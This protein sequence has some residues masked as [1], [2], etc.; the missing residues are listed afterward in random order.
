MVS[1]SRIALSSDR[2]DIA[3]YSYLL[4]LAKHRF[5]KEL[6]RTEKRQPMQGSSVSLTLT[7]Q[8]CEIPDYGRFVTKDEKWKV[9]CEKLW[10]MSPNWYDYC[11]GKKEN[12][13]RLLWYGHHKSSTD[14]ISVS[15]PH[16]LAKID[17]K[18][19]FEK[20]KIC[21]LV[22]H[23]S[24]YSF[25]VINIHWSISPLTNLT[26]RYKQ[27]FSCGFCPTCWVTSSV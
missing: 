8:I 23:Y 26:R 17:G 7:D 13:R 19:R 2:Q 1:L 15:L 22:E 27:T 20:T 18:S 9:V 10:K 12:R 25:F 6:S 16:V 5:P 21:L 11:Q 24:L 3:D 14:S 4:I